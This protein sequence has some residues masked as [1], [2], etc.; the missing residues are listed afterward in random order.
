MAWPLRLRQV[1]KVE[2]GGCGGTQPPQ[3][4]L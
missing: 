4:A 1:L 2:I 3:I